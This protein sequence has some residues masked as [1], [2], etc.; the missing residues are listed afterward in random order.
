MS[1]AEL[2]AHNYSWTQICTPSLYFRFY[3]RFTLSQLGVK[4]SSRTGNGLG[5]SRCGLGANNSFG[6]RALLDV[7]FKLTLQEKKIKSNWEGFKNAFSNMQM[8]LGKFNMYANVIWRGELKTFGWPGGSAGSK[9]EI[10]CWM[11]EWGSSTGQGWLGA[12]QRWNLEL[13]SKARDS[14]MGWFL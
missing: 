4:V 2:A 3:P 1:E 11:G 14:E 7:C 9:I 12:P 5:R 8:M 13:Y 6:S 10:Y